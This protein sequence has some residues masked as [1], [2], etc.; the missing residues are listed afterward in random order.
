MPFS[1]TL[2][3]PLA[4][5]RLD[6]LGWVGQG[7]NRP[8]CVLATAAGDLFTAD[9][10][11]GVA[12]THADGRQS[13]YAAQPM[14]GETLK[15]N[16][17]ALLKDGAFLL[18]HLGAE[19]GG[20]FHLQRNGQTRP[21]LEQVDG[22]DLPP[23]NFVVEDEAGRFWLTV[24]T[25]QQPRA[26]GYRRSCADGFIVMID[27]KGARIVADGLGYT[28]EC[29]VDVSGQWLYFN[30]TFARR[31]SRCAIRAD[32]SLGAREVVATFGP[33]TFP[34]GLTADA[35]GGFWVTSIVSN[36]VIHVAP[37]GVQT[38]W[39]EDSEPDHLAWVEQAYESSQMGRPHLD[40]VKSRVLRNISSLAFGGADLRTGYLGCLLGDRLATVRMPVAGHPPIHWSYA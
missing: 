3:E 40:G 26:L 11:G 32:G 12:H 4:P 36:R 39:L 6:G 14:D 22:M 18:A 1:D 17:I 31:L 20:V 28:N 27:G 7:L 16:G 19:R 8:E 2:I 5:A 25:R 15:P 38:L 24:S 21:W 35:E 13:F 33:G 23:S 10:R 37:D 34:D 9:W 29:A 30:E